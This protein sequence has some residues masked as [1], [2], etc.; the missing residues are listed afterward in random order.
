MVKADFKLVKIMRSLANRY[1]ELANLRNRYVYA[2]TSGILTKGSKLLKSKGLKSFLFT[3]FRLLN[4]PAY[5]MISKLGFLL[6]TMLK[7]SDCR[8][9]GTGLIFYF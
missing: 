8:I 2:L 5:S 3:A 9:F 7:K 1:S 4:I 6:M